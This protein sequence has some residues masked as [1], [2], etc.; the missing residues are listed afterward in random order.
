MAG[1]PG[2]V[3]TNSY[4]W[5]PNGT[6]VGAYTNVIGPGLCLYSYNKYSCTEN[7]GCHSIVSVYPFSC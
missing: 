3:Q 4:G 6:K 1:I 2:L 7:T 5:V